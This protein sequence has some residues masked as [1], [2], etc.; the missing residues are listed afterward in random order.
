MGDAFIT[1]GQQPWLSACDL[2]DTWTDPWAESHLLS[3]LSAADLASRGRRTLGAFSSLFLSRQAF[4][5][6]VHGANF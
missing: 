6:G 3:L 1:I 2:N 4:L 5:T